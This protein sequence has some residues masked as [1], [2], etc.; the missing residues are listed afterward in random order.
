[1]MGKYIRVRD[2]KKDLLDP[3]ILIHRVEGHSDLIKLIWWKLT[4]Q[5]VIDNFQICLREFCS[6]FQPHVRKLALW[7][8]NRFQLLTLSII[9]HSPEYN[10][11]AIM[12][13]C[14]H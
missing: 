7:K 2:I 6:F 13:A 8:C 5:T 12:S 10:L 1:M 14:K 3:V 11:V 9:I 4:T